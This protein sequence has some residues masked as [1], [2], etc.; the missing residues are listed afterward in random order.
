MSKFI[1]Q[2]K[3]QCVWCLEEIEI[4][5]ECQFWRKKLY[6]AVCKDEAYLEQVNK[7]EETE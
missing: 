7:V 6:H 1:A 4:G 3:D 5:Q 2:Y